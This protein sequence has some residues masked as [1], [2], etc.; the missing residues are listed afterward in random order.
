MKKDYKKAIA[1]S[2][3]KEVDEKMEFLSNFRL[4]S[5]LHEAKL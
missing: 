5:T 1:V 4:F 3:K 2:F